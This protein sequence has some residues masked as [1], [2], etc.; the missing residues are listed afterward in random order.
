[1]AEASTEAVALDEL[2]RQVDAIE[3][4]ASGEPDGLRKRT[5]DPS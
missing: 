2:R 4:A 1:M 5:P 3:D